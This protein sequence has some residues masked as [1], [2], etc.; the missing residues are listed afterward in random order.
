MQNSCSLLN[1]ASECEPHHIDASDQEYDSEV[2]TFPHLIS[3]L[4]NEIND[5]DERTTLDLISKR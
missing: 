4:Q 2:L 1:V 5:P 3:S